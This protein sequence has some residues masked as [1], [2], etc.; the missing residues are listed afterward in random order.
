MFYTES[1][2]LSGPD[3]DRWQEPMDEGFKGLRQKGNIKDVLLPTGTKFITTRFVFR[4]KR[5]A[6]GK[7]RDSRSDLWSEAL[8]DVPE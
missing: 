1:E 4:T 3:A 7:M 8:Q 2:A 5:A 6:D